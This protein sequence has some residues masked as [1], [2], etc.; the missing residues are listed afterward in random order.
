MSTDKPA[1]KKVTRP[2]RNGP[3]P[4]P[5]E[6]HRRRGNPGKKA[7]PE[8]AT[9]TALPAVP[10]G[11]IPTPPRPLGTDGAALWERAWKAG[12]TWMSD[13]S[14]VD[15]LLLLCESLDE[16]SALRAVVLEEGGWRERSA[17]RALDKQIIDKLQLLGFTPSDR[18]RL[19]VAEV[20]ADDDLEAY[21]KRQ[22]GSA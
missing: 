10:A 12:R 19:G 21:R 5:T 2:R 11:V 16:R 9:V 15:V 4:L 14:D 22:T 1:Q 6:Q 3:A 17:L 20:K 7:L 13:Q 18:A 8:E